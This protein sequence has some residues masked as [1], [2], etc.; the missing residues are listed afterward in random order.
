MTAQPDADLELNER[1]RQIFPPSPSARVHRSCLKNLKAALSSWAL[2]ILRDSHKQED[3]E[4]RPIQVEDHPNGYPR[5]SALIASHDSFFISRRFS[6]LR[7]RLLLLKQ[8]R[9]AILEQRLGRIDREESD[10]LA[11]GSTR[12]DNSEERSSVLSEID[13][14]LADY[15]KLVE[16]N[17]RIFG[18]EAPKTRSLAGLR[19][20][21]DGNGCIARAETAYL[22]CSG[23][24]ASGA[25]TDDTVMTWLETVVEDG[26]VGMRRRFGKVYNGFDCFYFWRKYIWK[27]IGFFFSPLLKSYSDYV[28]AHG[29]GTSSRP[30]YIGYS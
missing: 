19:N 14:A 9:L 10:M 2:E 16:R 15:D 27:L 18:L 28:A 3:L 6:G 5:Y 25:D 23:D 1:G 12:S 24:L 13:E 8:D 30:I 20:W 7:A 4:R 29:T 22:G 26:L 21:V 17:H 11:L